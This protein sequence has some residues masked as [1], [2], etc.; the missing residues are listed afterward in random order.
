MP[1][2]TSAERVRHTVHRGQTSEA[3]FVLFSGILFNIKQKHGLR[4][5]KRVRPG[6]NVELHMCRI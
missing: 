4:M 3:V 6:L 2:E 1:K 5:Y